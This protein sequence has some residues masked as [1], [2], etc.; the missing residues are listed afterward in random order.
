MILAVSASLIQRT[1]KIEFIENP[2][3]IYKMTNYDDRCDDDIIA[4]I[5]GTDFSVFADNY[6]KINCT[7]K[8]NPYAFDLFYDSIYRAGPLD[9]QV[10]ENG[11]DVDSVEVDESIMPHDTRSLIG[12]YIDGLPL[13]SLDPN[14]LK[15]FMYKLLEQASG[16]IED[17]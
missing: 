16:V 8:N 9:I 7:G 12:S 1:R 3:T 14:R 2:H 4:K 6:V 11:F 15:A 5:N 10:I 13:N 17:E